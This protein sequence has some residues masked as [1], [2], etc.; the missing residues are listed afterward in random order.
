MDNQEGCRFRWLAETAQRE[1]DREEGVFS[2][3][4]GQLLARLYK[5]QRRGTRFVELYTCI[6]LLLTPLTE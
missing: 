4:D 6:D 3:Q 2:Q 5:C 1:R